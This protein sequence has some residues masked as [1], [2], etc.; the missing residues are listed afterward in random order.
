MEHLQPLRLAEEGLELLD[1]RRLPGHE[2]WFCC[3]DEEEVARA[4]EDLAVRGAPA[5]GIAAA[6]GYY[7]GCRR[8]GAT[9]REAAARHPIKG[10]LAATRPTARN[11][12]WALDRME[13]V[14]RA[15]ATLDPAS[16]LERLRVEAASIHREDIAANRAIGRSGQPLIHDGARVLTHCNAGALATGG[17]GTALGVLRA[18]R[19]AGKRVNVIAGETRPLLQGSRLTAWELGREGFPVTVITDGMAAY[20]MGRREVDVVLVGADRIAANGDTANKIGTYGLAL[21]TAIHGLPFYVAAPIS[22]I[23]LSMAD[24]SQIAIEQR[25]AGEVVELAGARL[26]PEGAGAANPA[27]DVTPHRYLTAIIT[28]KGVIRPPFAAGLARVAGREEEMC[29]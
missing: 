26:A 11:L 10:R 14:A 29:P 2:T 8:L 9:A 20:F 6:Y 5:I 4:I 1:Q 12:F 24:G 23:D 7:L 25:S 18:A 15:N 19:E 21:L 17:Y 27:F 28:E 16:F 3:R 13:R 22:T